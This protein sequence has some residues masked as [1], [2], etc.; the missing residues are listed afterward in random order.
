MIPPTYDP[1]WPEDV[2]ALYHHDMREMWDPDIAPHIWS[3]YHDHLDRYRALAGPAPKR[4][5]DVGCAQ[6]TL[7]LLLAEQGHE[8][9]AV[10][11]RPQFLEYARSRYSHGQ[12]RF[13]Q[14]NA[15]EDELPGGFDLVFANQIIEHLVYPVQFLE[16]LR[17]LLVPGGQLVA[18][19]PNGEY[20]KNSLPSYEALGNP[21]DWE[22]MQ[23]SADGDGHFFAYR[24]QEL[25]KIFAA[26]GFSDARC[27]YFETPFINGHL[28][29]RYLHRGMPNRPLRW[30]DRG[31]LR[32]GPI[33]SRLSHQLLASGTNPA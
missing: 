29:L 30:V 33:A 19:T 20:L 24:R 32:F 17:R 14:A 23:F 15:L 1:A 13:L 8:V 7:A 22:H 5:L 16:R 12:I 18:T 2:K 6:G 4:I 9:T 26:A 10:D 25:L 28:K 3:W 31:L 11:I 21:A 27:E